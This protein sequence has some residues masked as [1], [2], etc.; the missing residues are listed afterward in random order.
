MPTETSTPPSPIVE[1]HLDPV[2]PSSAH[3]PS[4]NRLILLLALVLAAGTFALYAPALS[5][6]FV[7]YD[8]S[9]Y[10]TQNSHVLQGLTWPNIVWA[11]G[12]DHPA[13]NWHPLTWISHMVDY[14]LYG[15]SDDVN[16][17]T[18][19]VLI[20]RLRKRLDEIG[21]DCSIHTLRGIGY[22]LRERP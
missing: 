14:E 20:S 6:G 11:F 13:A 8:D 2:S 7:N 17:N 15:L 19:E 9:D 22:L 10:V 4:S 21:A 5:N 16:P 12:T 1:T 3:A 18:V